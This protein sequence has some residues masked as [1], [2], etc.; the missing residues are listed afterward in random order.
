MYEQY[1]NNIIAHEESPSRANNRVRINATNTSNFGF[2]ESGN[3]VGEQA[4][5]MKANRERQFVN[6]PVQPGATRQ[7]WQDSNIF[8]TK[9]DTDSIQKSAMVQRPIKERSSQTY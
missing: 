2:T 3:P 9:T 7:S 8:S 4:A 5:R 1:G 6:N